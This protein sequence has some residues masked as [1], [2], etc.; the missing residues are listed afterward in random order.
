MQVSKIYTQIE[1]KVWVTLK[2]NLVNKPSMLLAKD[3]SNNFTKE[4]FS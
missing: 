2:W 1:P 3:V 4:I